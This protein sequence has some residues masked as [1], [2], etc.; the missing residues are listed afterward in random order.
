MRA[1]HL[2]RAALRRFG[3]SKRGVAA[4]EFA[5]V[6]PMMLFIAFGIVEV[7]F[8]LQANRRVE[9]VAS[10]LADIISRDDNGVSQAELDDLWNAVRPLMW[11]SRDT[12]MQVRVSSVLIT[13]P[14]R[15]EVVWSEGHGGYAPRA[16][17]ST[18]TLPSGMMTQGSS[19]ILGE[20][21]YP[22]EP[23]IGFVFGPN[24]LHTLLAPGSASSTTFNITHQSVRR[25]RF[26]DPVPRI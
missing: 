2:L 21:I 5:I 25:S 10:S 20:V 23:A 12:G 3:R 1:P 19:F 7:T 9:N 15:A 14:T 17:A 26:I 8:A 6:A 24:G 22:Y 16:V 11:P 13:S 18:V 4:V